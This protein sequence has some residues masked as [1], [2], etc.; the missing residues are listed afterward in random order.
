MF[1]SVVNR[2]FNAIIVGI[3]LFLLAFTIK[4]MSVSIILLGSVGTFIGLLWLN[5]DYV[6]IGVTI[7][8]SILLFVVASAGSE[9]FGM[10]IFIIILLWS[11]IIEKLIK[12]VNN[13]STNN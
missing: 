1:L 6:D 10:M 12:I 9:V 7:V 4:E 8:T 2:L 5:N 11:T 3:G 13:E